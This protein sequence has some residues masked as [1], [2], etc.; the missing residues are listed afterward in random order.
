MAAANEF[1]Y[2]RRVEFADTDMAGIAHF[3]SLLRYMEEAE[4]AFLRHAGIGVVEHTPQGTISWPRVQIQCEFQNPARFGEL[5]DIAVTVEEIG[6]KKIAYRFVA[7]R[8][9]V[10]IATG[11]TVAVCCRVDDRAAIRAVAIPATILQKLV[12]SAAPESPSRTER[13]GPI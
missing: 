12:P 6:D 13:P 11:R 9:E 2:S 7:R 4:H 3:T 8:G 10:R 5:L 1:H